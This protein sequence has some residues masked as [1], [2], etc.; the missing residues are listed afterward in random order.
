MIMNCDHKTEIQFVKAFNEKKYNEL[1]DKLKCFIKYINDGK[2]LD[3]DTQIQAE[4]IMKKVPSSSQHISDFPCEKRRHK[5]KSKADVIIK[6]NNLE[7]KIS[8]KSG[9]ANSNHQEHWKYFNYLLRHHGAT[10]NEISTFKEF[11]TSRDIRYFDNHKKEKKIMQGFFDRNKQELLIHFLKTGYCSEEGFAEFLFHG[12][13]DN[14]ISNCRYASMDKI[15]KNILKTIPNSRADLHICGLTVQRWNVCPKNNSKL[16]TIQV[17]FGTIKN[18]I[19][20]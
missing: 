6:F 11:I 19:H 17:K 7:K 15:I 18:Y 12:D 1:S 16:D 5:M 9:T 4:C 20:E 8:L 10:N 3:E 14:I 13:K 2:P